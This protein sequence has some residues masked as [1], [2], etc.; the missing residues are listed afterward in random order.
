VGGGTAN[1]SGEA[2]RRGWMRLQPHAPSRAP[3]RS[4]RRRRAPWRTRR[5]GRRVCGPWASPPPRASCWPL[6][7]Q[8][9]WCWRWGP[10]SSRCRSPAAV[11]EGCPCG[12]A[13]GLAACPPHRDGVNASQWIE[14]RCET[15]ARV[16]GCAQGLLQKEMSER[17]S[18]YAVFLAGTALGVVTAAASLTA[19]RYL[20]YSQTPVSPDKVRPLSVFPLEAPPHQ[21]PAALGQGMH[22]TRTAYGRL[23]A[24]HAPRRAK[25]A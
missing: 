8:T 2:L 6:A 7:S 10:A 16:A 4:A 5:C 9:D 19:A 1:R 11:E 25:R 12:A 14:H 20:L 17:S 18:G 3:R 21:R 13:L 15:L 22:E 23:G 24:S